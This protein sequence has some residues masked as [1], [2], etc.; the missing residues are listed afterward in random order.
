MIYH[1]DTQLH[2]QQKLDI[3]LSGQAKD[4]VES[5]LECEN[6][7]KLNLGKNITIGPVPKSEVFCSVVCVLKDI[8]NN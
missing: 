6:V 7:I 3:V 5:N 8:K 1:R 2:C 4:K